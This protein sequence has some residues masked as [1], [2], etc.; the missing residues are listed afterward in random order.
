MWAKCP[1]LFKALLFG[2]VLFFPTILLNQFLLFQN[3][4]RSNTLPWALPIILIILWLY[5]KFTTGADKPFK[6]SDTRRDLSRASFSFEGN[7]PWVVM[8]VLGIMFFTL[9]MVSVGYAFVYEETDQL[10]MITMFF[11]APAQT[12]IPLV[13]ALSLTAGIVEEIVFRG[14]VQTMLERAYGVMASFL[15]T[16]IIFALLHFL[17]TVLI[18]PYVLVSLAFSYVAYK[19]RS[20]VPGIIAHAAFDFFAILLLFFYP[21]VKTQAYFQ[22]TIYLNLILVAVSAAAIWYSMQK[23]TP[24]EKLSENI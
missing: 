15:I 21:V 16:A 6:L 9:S 24:A 10:A 1:V 3:L 19:S 5:W 18:L 4:W 12:A 7:I 2:A 11:E 20:V 23:V 22:D 17:P 13:F 14:Y 8:A